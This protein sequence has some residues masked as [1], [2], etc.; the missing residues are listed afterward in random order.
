MGSDR[1]ERWLKN[2]YHTEEDE[3][4][5]SEC[6]ERVSGFVELELAGEDPAAR[7]PEVRQHLDQCPACREEYQALRDLRQLEEEGELPSTDD[8]Q[9][10]IP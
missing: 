2:I 8:L 1:F 4:S 6:F 5:C 3:I 10:L 9:D 7:M